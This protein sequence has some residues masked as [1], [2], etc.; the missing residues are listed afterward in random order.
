V[1]YAGT[2]ERYETHRES[3]HEHY[4]GHKQA[5]FDISTRHDVVG[6]RFEVMNCTY[7]SPRSH[8]HTQNNYNLMSHHTVHHLPGLLRNLRQT[9]RKST[10]LTSTQRRAIVV[11]TVLGFI[12][13]AGSSTPTDAM[14]K[15]FVYLEAPAVLSP[16]LPPFLPLPLHPW[17]SVP[18]DPSPSHTLQFEGSAYTTQYLPCARKWNGEHVL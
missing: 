16:F 4:C 14:S 12:L 17:E 10:S 9:T 5:A 3:A 15:N 11:G 8:T 18:G 2:D 6:E 7:P 13:L 1:C